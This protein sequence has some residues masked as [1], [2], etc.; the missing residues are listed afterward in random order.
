VAAVALG[1]SSSGKDVH[2]TISPLNVVVVGK[3]FQ[4]VDVD[5][6]VVDNEKAPFKILVE[7]GRAR[8]TGEVLIGPS[9]RI[10][11]LGKPFSFEDGAGCT[12]HGDLGNP[13]V[14][15]KLRWEWPEGTIWVEFKGTPTPFN[16]DKLSYTS[17]TGMTTD[18]IKQVL[19]TGGESASAQASSNSGAPGQG[20]ATALVASQ[21]S[22]QLGHGLSTKVG[23]RDDGTLQPGLEYRAGQALIGVS[24]YDASGTNAGATMA[25]GAAPKGQ[26]S[27]ITIDWRFWK[28]W[29]LRGT[30]DVGSDQQTL[31]ADMLWQHRY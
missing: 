4:G 31:G 16:E 19:L 17:A 6:S 9:S 23:T 11:L 1:P 15:A 21:L 29:S 13:F 24:T 12:W 22:T 27:V 8:G 2:V 14:N 20:M 28:A 26:H 3:P 30:V 5:V 18:H 10:E 7:G 25:G